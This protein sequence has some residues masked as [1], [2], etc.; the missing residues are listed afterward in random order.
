MAGSGWPAKIAEWLQ[1]VSPLKLNNIVDSLSDAVIVIEK[2][3][4]LQ[5]CN[6]HWSRLSGHSPKNSQNQVFSQ[7]IHPEDRVSWQVAL[8]KFH[9]SRESQLL[10]LR[11]IDTSGEVHWCEIRVQPIYEHRP[12][13]VSAT[14]CDITPQIRSDQIKEARYRSLNS[15]VN[16]VPAMIYRSRNNVHWTMEYVSDGCLELTGYQPE[17][18]VNNSELS[19]GSLIHADDR[20]GVWCNVQKAIQANRSFELCYR[21]LHA[22][23]EIRRVHE[24]GCAI[25]SDSGSIL[26]I[27]GVIFSLQTS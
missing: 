27:E 18:M 16:R 21:L 6:Q 25:Y 4:K 3:N 13:P 26:G 7:F 23:G 1:G 14:L 10:W 9:Q 20:E 5:Y 19:Y 2:H 8:Q 12:F 24:K 22:S 15:L 11:I 17:K